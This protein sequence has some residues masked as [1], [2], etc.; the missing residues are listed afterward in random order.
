MTAKDYFTIIDEIYEWYGINLNIKQLKKLLNNEPKLLV[1]YL[2][3]CKGIDTDLREQIIDLLAEKY[4]GLSWPNGSTSKK[5]TKFFFNK[6][7][8]ELKKAH[9]KYDENCEEV[10]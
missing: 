4:V 9:I 5:E 7:K 1:D 2:Y 8:K 3:P 10:L 6:L